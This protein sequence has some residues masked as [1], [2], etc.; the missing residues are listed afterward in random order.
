M[1]NGS[2]CQVVV[3]IDV[4]LGSF[5]ENLEYWLLE[6]RN[7]WTSP[8]SLNIILFQIKSQI[9]SDLEILDYEV[10][11]PN[12]DISAQ[13]VKRLS[14]QLESV[15]LVFFGK[16]VQFKFGDWIAGKNFPLFV[17]FISQ[18]IVQ[19]QILTDVHPVLLPDV[20]DDVVL[21]NFVQAGNSEVH[22]D[23][24]VDYIDFLVIKHHEEDPDWAVAYVHQDNLL[25][26]GIKVSLSI[27]SSVVQKIRQKSRWLT[28]EVEA[29]N[30][31]NL[32][33]LSHS[34]FFSFSVVVWQGNGKFEILL[35][36]LNSL[37]DVSEESC[38][39]LR[40]L[41]DH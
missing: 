3:S 28:Y 17:N 23:R 40:L 36:C 31:G 24:A 18:A 15:I 35:V 30:S 41:E 29:F 10:F 27:V 19:L 34:A 38:E 22:F 6:Q 9:F 4:G 5:V 20:V 32:K 21:E 39:N 33:S 1:K 25:S 12:C 2:F 16:R 8:Y 7:P 13:I 14:G 26:V 11:K 37:Q